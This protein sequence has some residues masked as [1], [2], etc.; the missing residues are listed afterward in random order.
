MKTFRRFTVLLLALLLLLSGCG[1]SNTEKEGTMGQN[2]LEFVSKMKIGWNLGNTL[3]ASG[4]GLSAET[5]WGNPKTTEE[6]ILDIRD[7]GFD[8]LRVPVSWGQHCDAE[9]TVDAEWMARVQEVVDYA[10]ENGMY[11]ILN[12]HHDNAYYDI[13]GCVES[14]ETLRKSVEKMKALWTQIAE[15]FRDYGER[16]LFETLNEPRT[17]GSPKEWMGGT[18]EERAVV[19]ELNREIVGAIRATGGKNASRYILV[20]SYAATSDSGV[21]REMELPEDDRI[22]MSVHAYA[23]YNFAM[24]DKAP[25]TFTDSDKRE[26]DGLFQ[27]LDELF[28]QKG[29]PVILGEFGATN[30]N[31]PEDRCAW[32]DYYVRSAKRLGIACVVWDNNRRGVGA[33]NFGLYDR[34]NRT[35]FFPELA[36]AYVKAAE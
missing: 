26:L 29:V 23:P 12:S 8:T 32:A 24:N 4:F 34:Y 3:D 21:L 28:I 2:S 27:S 20:P 22:I 11:V 18:P 13:G 9:G 19:Y 1:T 31:N 17:E 33:E 15:H 10:Y 14:E 6:M 7:M 35:W 36:E 25:G 16:L 30:K 5:G